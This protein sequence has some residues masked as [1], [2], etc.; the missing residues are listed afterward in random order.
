MC[1]ACIGSALY[2]LTGAG[3]AG[4]VVMIAWKAL[5]RAPRDRGSTEEQQTNLPSVDGDRRDRSPQRTDVI[6]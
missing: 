4:G 2:A 5:R 3:S 6:P 1:P